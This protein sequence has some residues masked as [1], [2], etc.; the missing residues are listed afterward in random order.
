MLIKISVPTL[1]KYF[2]IM[3]EAF[4]FFDLR[5]FSYKVKDQLQYPR[6]LYAVDPWLANF[7]GF[8]FSEDAGRLMENVVAVEL[9][10]RKTVSPVREVY[11]WKDKQQREVDFVLKDGSKIKQLIQ[12][13][14]ASSKEEIEMR[15][16]RALIKASEELNCDNMLI[17]TWDY[18]AE[19]EFKGKRIKVTPLWKWLF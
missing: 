19:E 10:R 17:I 5:I 4:L 18:E 7:S 12:V 11:Y 13:T 6:K 8:K 3:K 9:M 16:K 2:Y 14:Y 1:E 15:E